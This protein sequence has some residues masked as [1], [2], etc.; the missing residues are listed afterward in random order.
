MPSPGSVPRFPGD[1]LPLGCLL[2]RAPLAASVTHTFVSLLGYASHLPCEA[3]RSVLVWLIV[4]IL[5]IGNEVHPR[6]K[7]EVEA[8]ATSCKRLG[9]ITSGGEWVAAK[10]AR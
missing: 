8:N 7:Q 10:Q 1:S 6:S 5:N 3:V 2:L 9:A 4:A